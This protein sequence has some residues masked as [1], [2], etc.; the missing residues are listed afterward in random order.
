[1]GISLRVGA[2]DEAI[3]TVSSFKYLGFML[4]DDGSFEDDVQR[5]CMAAITA[6]N[7]NKAYIT[8]DR[9]PMRHRIAM[10]NVQVC[11]AL[12]FGAESWVLTP[13][14]EHR[15]RTTYNSLLRR[16]ARIYWYQKI[17]TEELHAITRTPPFERIAASRKLRWYG[18][19][20]RMNMSRQAASILAHTKSSG[21]LFYKSVVEAAKIATT[22]FP[23]RQV[24]PW[25][26]IVEDRKQW[27]EFTAARDDGMT[28]DRRRAE[29]RAQ[30]GK[31][32][33]PASRSRDAPL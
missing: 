3:E 17:S 15:L 23:H 9:I 10:F 16:A 22:W 29:F 32:R 2:N 6:F 20:S 30:F 25:K 21:D 7:K 31:G 18:H 28:W 33:Q 24:P 4:R 14:Q 5:R 8:N 13:K 26:D 12:F 19:L 1:M 27:R 11:S